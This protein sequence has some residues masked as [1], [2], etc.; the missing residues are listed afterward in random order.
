MTVMTDGRR[1][2]VGFLG[3]S[4]LLA[5]LVVV[6]ATARRAEGA[7]TPTSNVDRAYGNQGVAAIELS[8][9]TAIPPNGFGVAP[10]GGVMAL[11]GEHA[12]QRVQPNGTLDAAF[13][14]KAASADLAV[15]LVVDALGRTT[16]A[17]ND[18]EAEGSV[19]LRRFL[20]SGSPDPTFGTAG[21]SASIP[22]G[23]ENV[24]NGAIA[25]D[26]QGRTLVLVNRAASC[27][28]VRVTAAGVLDTGYGTA[29][30][31][32]PDLPKPQG[33]N[34]GCRQLL[35]RSDDGVYVD[36]ILAAARLDASG[37]QQPFGPN[38]ANRTAA[39]LGPSA[40]LADGR[41]ASVN[42]ADDPGSTSDFRGAM[43]VS[44]LTTAGVP[45]AT[46]G[47][48]GGTTVPL[49]ALFGEVSSGFSATP[50]WIAQRADG[51]LVVGGAAAHD[52]A[53]LLRL[54]LDGTLDPTYGQGG[55]VVV[56]SSEVPNAD[57][58]RSLDFSGV[59][60]LAPGDVPFAFVNQSPTAVVRGIVRIPGGADVTH[61]AATT[62][63]T[64]GPSGTVVTFDLTG[65]PAGPVYVWMHVD[66]FSDFPGFGDSGA[67]TFRPST[68]NRTTGAI[69]IRDEPSAEYQ[70]PN[71]TYPIEA[72][73]TT[74]KQQA[75]I[76]T[77]R[78]TAPG[79]VWQVIPLR[80]LQPGQVTHVNG[81][82]NDG[83]SY[84]SSGDRAVWWD[85]AGMPHDL[86]TY[87]G[88]TGVATGASGN[89]AIVGTITCP[90]R[91]WGLRWYH[92][93]G[94]TTYADNP[95][96]TEMRDI[97]DSKVAVGQIKGTD[98]KP[99]AFSEAQN[100][101]PKLLPDVGLSS[102]A[103]ATTTSGYT[104]GTVSGL[105]ALAAG[106]P[107]HLA[108]GWIGNQVF[109]LIPVPVETRAVDVNE[110][111][112]ALVQIAQ[113]GD[114][115]AV[116]VGPDGKITPLDS[117]GASDHVVA[118]DGW[119]LAVGTRV[120]TQG[121]TVGQWYA[122][123]QAVPLSSTVSSADAAAWDLRTPTGINDLLWVVG[124]T[125]DGRSW[126]MRTPGT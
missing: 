7:P 3:A 8:G 80:P 76:G 118:L 82:S 121:A 52:S 71:H 110:S 69:V 94:G 64:S 23:G 79:S 29:G 49:T 96:P 91:I 28:I 10:D 20:A 47:S 105:D 38:G 68:E 31:A 17:E 35:V 9:W 73:C 62:A 112:F 65:C 113:P 120:T 30:I 119:N 77:F 67:P 53:V 46:F 22:T 6:P 104:V 95:Y 16:T 66:G 101:A 75:T 83:I 19:R 51:K 90:G 34:L 111:G 85:G 33:T 125:A 36:S 102:T 25:L 86:G 57:P 2:R 117:G 48:G 11:V 124:N 1:V 58:S 74:T 41:I 40:L 14:A 107:A 89:N 60:G 26:H 99:H 109:P 87:A 126:F 97:A 21:V 44:V 32:T 84:G 15:E 27:G 123:G 39:G 103:A 4:L 59:G 63:P 70:T 88:C 13:A 61:L 122:F 55:V 24:A 114:D 92:S 42:P 81:T 54:R 56:R 50:G 98:G 12:L 5:V 100:Q 18:P 108:V 116:L 45:D 37:V 115:R 72:W 106:M 78:Y 93:Y 43:R